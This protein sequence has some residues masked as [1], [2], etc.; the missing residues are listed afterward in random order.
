MMPWKAA[1]SMVCAGHPPP[2]LL[3]ANG[4]TQIAAGAQP[5]LGVMEGATFRSDTCHLSPGDVLLCVTDGVTERRSGDRLHDDNGLRQRLSDCS[6]LSGGAIVA[7][8]QREACEFGSGTP[9]DDMALLVFRA[10]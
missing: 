4:G 2:L 9:A 6:G 7:R 1:V 10:Q 8:I 3:R 5:L